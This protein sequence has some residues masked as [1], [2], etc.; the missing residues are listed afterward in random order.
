[1]NGLD[2]FRSTILALAQ[3]GNDG[4]LVEAIEASLRYYKKQQQAEPPP[5]RQAALPVPSL[6]RPSGASE[7]TI[8]PV[9][10]KAR[11]F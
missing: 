5:Q 11:R 10:N 6:P 7:L 9:P 4:K 8:R 3:H 2:G 1:M